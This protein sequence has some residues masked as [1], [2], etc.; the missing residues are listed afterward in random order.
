MEP[1]G[2]AVSITVAV[3]LDGV[4]RKAIGRGIPVI[5]FS[6]PDLLTRGAIH[7]LPLL[8]RITIRWEESG[9]TCSGTCQSRRSSM[10]KLVLCVNADLPTADW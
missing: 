9:R 4:L 6:A 2:L 3:A 7:I 10:P 1:D 5:A 8:E